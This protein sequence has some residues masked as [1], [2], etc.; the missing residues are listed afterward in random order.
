MQR[1]RRVDADGRLMG[2]GVFSDAVVVEAGDVR[3]VKLSGIAAVDPV[4]GAVAGYES[5]NG[6]FAPDALELQV[7]DVFRQAERL[8]EAVSA[9]AGCRVGL[10]HLVE[11]LVFLREDQP[12]AFGRFNDAYVAEFQKRGIGD[13][14]ARTTVLRASLPEPNALVEIRFEAVVER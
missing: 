2:S 1:V 5:H 10:E 6:T 14:P 11:A 13:Y 4:S 9:E 12:M 7:A 3:I 8:L